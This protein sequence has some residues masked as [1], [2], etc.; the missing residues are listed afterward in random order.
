[1]TALTVRLCAATQ[2]TAPHPR[3]DRDSDV[4]VA[5]TGVLGAWVFGLN[6]DGLLNLDLIA[7]GTLA[8]VELVYPKGR[9]KTK[10]DIQRPQVVRSAALAFTEGAI[11]HKDFDLPVEVTADSAHSRVWIGIGEHRTGGHWVALSL[12]CLALIIGNELAGFFMSMECGT[13]KPSHK[14]S[15]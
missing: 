15:L 2:Q 12:S 9:W 11:G 7:D 6:I 13:P 10:P 4:L 3:Y 14:Y 1:M 8:H 5:K